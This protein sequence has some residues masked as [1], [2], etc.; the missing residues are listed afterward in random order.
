M[1]TVRELLSKKGCN[2]ISIGPAATVYDALSLMSVNDIG[3]LL[4]VENE[5]LL[6]IFSERDYARK[7]VLSG[8]SSH[9]TSVKEVM[10]THL[11][12]ITPENSVEDCMK[13][14]TEQHIRHLPVFENK[15]LVGIITIG[16]VV[17][18]VIEEQKNT[19]DDLEKYISG[20][21][22]TKPESREQRPVL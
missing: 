13:L 3:A 8:K 10:V 6:G 17:K 14:M 12:S 9:N 11:I 16:D 19:I 20:G 7:V 15:K 1:L 2:I 22:L 21:Y 5:K 18:D 4:V